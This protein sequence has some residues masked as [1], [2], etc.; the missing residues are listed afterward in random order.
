MPQIPS[1]DISA[2]TNPRS[3]FFLPGILPDSFPLNLPSFLSGHLFVSSTN[4]HVACL[5]PSLTP[6]PTP[7]SLGLQSQHR[8]STQLASSPPFFLSLLPARLQARRALW[9]TTCPILAPRL[10]T[11]TRGPDLP[12]ALS[13]HLPVSLTQLGGPQ[14]CH[15]LL[16]WFL[17]TGPVIAILTLV[18]H[19]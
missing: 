16:P 12:L 6:P 18:N 9:P 1:R 19:C 4:T 3:H 5:L 8:P 11:H 15:H 14:R 13:M 7:R 10:P 17:I 2:S